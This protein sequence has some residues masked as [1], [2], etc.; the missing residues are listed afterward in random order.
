MKIKQQREQ[1][2]QRADREELG[3]MRL[4]KIERSTP[5]LGSLEEMPKHE[6]NLEP[7][8]PQVENPLKNYNEMY[9]IIGTPQPKK[10]K[11]ML[12]KSLFGRNAVS[13]DVQ[14]PGTARPMTDRDAVPT[15]RSDAVGHVR[16]VATYN[17]S[18]TQLRG[19]GKNPG[20]SLTPNT[21]DKYEKELNEHVQTH[22]VTQ[23]GSLRLK[24]TN[25]SKANV[26]RIASTYG[27]T[28]GGVKSKLHRT[29]D[30][31]NNAL[32]SSSTHVDEVGDLSDDVNRNDET[33]QLNHSSD[34]YDY[35][36]SKSDDDTI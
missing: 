5:S 28:E 33:G 7:D 30:R 17:S 16:G 1:A 24:S 31:Q 8:T 4:K 14:T 35:G 36:E 25:E 23:N 10:S 2:L 26:K 34:Y 22:G 15:V 6:P 13:P 32:E 18:G 21:K 9:E 29:K 12:L 19:T 20:A 3:L 27:V 11:S